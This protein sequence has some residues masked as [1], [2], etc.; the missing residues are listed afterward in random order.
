VLATSRTF[1]LD[2]IDARPVR[3][4]ADVHQGLPAFAIVGLPDAAVREARERVRGAMEN[5]GYQFPTRRITINLAPASLRKAGP[6]FDLA[7]ATALL[8]ASGQIRWDALTSISITGELALD[9]SVRSVPGALAMAEAAARRGDDA[10]VP[11]PA[12]APRLR[13]RAA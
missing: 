7:I 13:W 12:T 9:G 5:S 3:V 6:G 4:E 11:P 8:A 1:A 2:G 10:L